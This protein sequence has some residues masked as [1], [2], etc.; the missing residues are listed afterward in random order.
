MRLGNPE[1]ALLFGRPE[2][3][4]SEYAIARGYDVVVTQ[5]PDRLLSDRLQRSGR[6]HWSVDDVPTLGPG[7]PTTGGSQLVSEPE[8]LAFPASFPSRSAR[9]V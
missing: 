7:W 2:L 9:T 3:V 8:P 5:R 6:A 1:L 4:I